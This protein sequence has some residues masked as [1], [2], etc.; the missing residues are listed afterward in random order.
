M[1]DI[2]NVKK[3]LSDK[4]RDLYLFTIGTNTNLKASD[5]EGITTGMIKLLEPGKEFVLIEKKTKKE[6]WIILNDTIQNPVKSF[7]S[8]RKDD[9]HPFNGRE[10]DINPIGVN[11]LV[12]K[13]VRMINL[14]GKHGSHS[15]RKV[16]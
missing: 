14:K 1:K 7:I 8:A 12:N 6:R 9:S 16:S 11:Y 15:R 4:P 13:W 10:E 3:F 2:N 5:L